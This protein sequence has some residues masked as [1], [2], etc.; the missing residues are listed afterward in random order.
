MLENFIAVASTSDRFYRQM[1]GSQVF[2]KQTPDIAADNLFRL[3]YIRLLS[4]EPKA[5]TG[6]GRPLLLL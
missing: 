6:T 1:W 2:V 3:R 4:G 5:Y